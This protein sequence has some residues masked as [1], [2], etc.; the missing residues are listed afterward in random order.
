MTSTAV[1]PGQWFSA[2]LTITDTRP[3]TPH[4]HTLCSNDG[5]ALLLRHWTVA[6]MERVTSPRLGSFLYYAQY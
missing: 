3:G 6:P 4:I 1:T 2:S 5:R